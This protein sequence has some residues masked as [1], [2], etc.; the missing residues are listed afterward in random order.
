[1]GKQS[2]DTPRYIGILQTDNLTLLSI[3][4]TFDALK[5]QTLSGLRITNKMIAVNIVHRGKQVL[6][7]KVS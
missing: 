6:M 4:I 3:N 1:M 5:W 2:A 7:L